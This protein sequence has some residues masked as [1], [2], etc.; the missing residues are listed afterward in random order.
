MFDKAGCRRVRATRLGV[1]EG[2]E[3]QRGAFGVDVGVAYDAGVVV[4][5]GANF[6]WREWA[7][8]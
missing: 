4:R 7:E 6:E 5:L 8:G 2:R 1:G 3:G